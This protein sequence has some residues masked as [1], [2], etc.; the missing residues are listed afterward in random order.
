MKTTIIYNLI[1]L[2]TILTMASCKN[3]TSN[4]STNNKDNSIEK[5]EEYTIRY[6][7]NDGTDKVYNITSRYLMYI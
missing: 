5:V 2:M 3:K 1:A 7:Q 6:M 4:T